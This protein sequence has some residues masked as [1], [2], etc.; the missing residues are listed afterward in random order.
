VPPPLK[1]TELL[2]L[3]RDTLNHNF[4]SAKLV[5]GQFSTDFVGPNSEMLRVQSDRFP[6]RRIQAVDTELVQ[7]A[8]GKAAAVADDADSPAAEWRK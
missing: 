6:F 1:L 8:D 5:S 7:S 3:C 2:R 4:N